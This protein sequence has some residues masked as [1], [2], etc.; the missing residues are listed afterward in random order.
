MN[1]KDEKKEISPFYTSFHRVKLVYIRIRADNLS[2]I[3]RVVNKITKDDIFSYAM[4]ESNN[5]T[6]K[7]ISR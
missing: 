5:D 7:N 3:G 4:T 6:M 1:N 2:F